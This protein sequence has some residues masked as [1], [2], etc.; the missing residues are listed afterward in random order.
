MTETNIFTRK[1][2]DAPMMSSA[3]TTK[4]VTEFHGRHFCDLPANPAPAIV[5]EWPTTCKSCASGRDTAS[6]RSSPSNPRNHIA[7]D[8]A[9]GLNVGDTP[10]STW[11]GELG[12]A[13]MR[14]TALMREF[15]DVARRE[16]TAVG[17]RKGY[18]YMADLA[19]DP[20]WQR[21]EGTF[22]EDPELAAQTI[23]AIVLG[24]RGR[25][26]TLPMA[27]RASP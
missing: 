23:R 1:P 22:G 14:D 16:W 5:A 12:L 18:M 11:P 3:G 24:F 2:L 6:R 13:A 9:A 15:A 20:R 8:V 21:T 27:I 10:F 17:I 19:T 26:C 4:A 25:P 7:V